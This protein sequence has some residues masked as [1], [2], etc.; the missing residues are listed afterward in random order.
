MSGRRERGAAALPHFHAAPVHALRTRRMHAADELT[1]PRARCLHPRYVT[2]TRGK[3]C[4]GQ[5]CECAFPSK[6]DTSAVLYQSA[7]DSMRVPYASMF[8]PFA[9]PWA[10]STTTRPSGRGCVKL[11]RGVAAGP[12]GRRLSA[13]R[14]RGAELV[15]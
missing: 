4:G 13:G 14:P 12:A 1:R 8:G 15:E 5:Q 9:D 3:R 6:I 7:K 2:V 11:F 10:G